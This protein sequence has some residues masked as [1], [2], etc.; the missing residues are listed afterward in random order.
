[1]T[2][3]RIA[4]FVVAMGLIP[5]LSLAE[6]VT[7]SGLV[8][9]TPSPVRLPTITEFTSQ[10]AWEAATDGE[11]VANAYGDLS[12]GTIVTD[13]YL[14]LG[15]IYTDGDDET[16]R[17]EASHDGMLLC[18]HGGIR[19][20]FAMPV[21]AVAV[22][23]PGAVRITGYLGDQVVFVSSD[24]GG[25]GTFKFAGLIS[26]DAFDR[27]EIV[28]WVDGA[29]Y[30]DDLDYLHFIVGAEARSWGRVKSLFR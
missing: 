5:W 29:A 1:M 22:N 14:A 23:F 3:F 12:A 18:G 2:G 7:N 9:A 25:C 20:D 10:E 19:V 8:F 26:G 13:Q 4:L 16:F 15:A 11:C 6:P 21:H 24:C 27:I 17:Y 28:D 30:I